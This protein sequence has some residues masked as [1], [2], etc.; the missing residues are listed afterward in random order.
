[1]TGILKG[2]FL[3]V[4]A[5][6]VALLVGS[7]DTGG[8]HMTFAANKGINEQTD[9]NQ[10][11]RCE[12]AGGTSGITNACTATSGRGSTQTP[13][14]VT[15]SSITEA[16]P[17]PTLTCNA[18]TCNNIGCQSVTCTVALPSGGLSNC[19]TNNG[20]QL[21]SCIEGSLSL[22]CTRTETGTGIINSGGV[23]GDDAG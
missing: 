1:M 11:Q 12:P 8:V 20:V 7:T 17:P 9:T 5:S 23:T 18:A 19:V 3:V 6:F 14:T 22:S 10:D 15:C 2:A 13:V 4:T 21:M 16:R